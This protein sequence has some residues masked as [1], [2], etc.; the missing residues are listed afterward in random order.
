MFQ[1][2]L[3]LSRNSGGVFPRCRFDN[4]RT[5]QTYEL[6][7]RTSRRFE[8]YSGVTGED[9]SEKNGGTYYSLTL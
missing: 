1:H 4:I 6:G 2:S 7:P 8:D 9:I 3:S 5:V